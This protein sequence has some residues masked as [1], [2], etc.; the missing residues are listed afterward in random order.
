MQQWSG[1]RSGTYSGDGTSPC[2]PPGVPLAH[3]MPAAPRAA[4]DA[5]VL[6]HVRRDLKRLFPGEQAGIATCL[7]W[8]HLNVP[9]RPHSAWLQTQS[10]PKAVTEYPWQ[11]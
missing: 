4:G 9:G 8:Q 1:R 3:C 5:A 6:E 2:L 7:S 10:E 11:R